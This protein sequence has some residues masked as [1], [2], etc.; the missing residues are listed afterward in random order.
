MCGNKEGM[1]LWDRVTLLPDSGVVPL[2]TMNVYCI[3]SH[4][5]GTFFWQ[6]FHIPA[7]E[8]LL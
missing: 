5:V 3:V 7:S 1:G 6:N 8:V 2:I 4:S